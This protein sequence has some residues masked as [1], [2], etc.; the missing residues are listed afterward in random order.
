LRVLVDHLAVVVGPAH[1]AEAQGHHQ[2]RPHQA[3]RKV[4][5]QEGG[6]AD[7][8]QDQHAAHGRGAVFFQV[9]LRAIG[10]HRLADLH[11][12]QLADDVRAGEQADQRGRDGREHRTEGDEVENTQGT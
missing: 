8:E 2:H 12:H 10:T 3:V 4:H 1:G 11:L 6:D 9:R 7:R 5:P